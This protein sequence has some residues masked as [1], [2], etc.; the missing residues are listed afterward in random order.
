V[1]LQ[2]LSALPSQGTKLVKI[3]YS[4]R[5]ATTAFMIAWSISNSHAPDCLGEL[6]VA[7]WVGAAGV[8]EVDTGC[9]LP[10]SRLAITAAPGCRSA[11]CAAMWRRRGFGGNQGVL[12]GLRG[13]QRLRRIPPHQ[14]IFEHTSCI[15]A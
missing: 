1:G 8:D 2:T 7:E 15:S 9:S 6:G 4:V 5:R 14:I 3:N 10:G 11:Q 12:V 13:S